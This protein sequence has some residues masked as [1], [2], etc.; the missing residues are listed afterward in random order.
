M[1]LAL[2]YRKWIPRRLISETRTRIN[3]AYG[4]NN[5]VFNTLTV[6]LT[7]YYSYNKLD[8]KRNL[9]N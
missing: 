2:S 6:L 3:C 1:E 9:L 5:T 4:L 7:D 8:V